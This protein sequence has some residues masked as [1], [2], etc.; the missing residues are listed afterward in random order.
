MEF[1]VIEFPEDRTVRID[2]QD[3]GVTNQTLM[4]E[5]G[6]HIFDLGEP[7]NYDPASVEIEV[8]DTTSI[9]P[10]IVSDFS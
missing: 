7:V 3:A 10:L 5:A 4:V 1:V 8:K 9:T 2:G 6:H